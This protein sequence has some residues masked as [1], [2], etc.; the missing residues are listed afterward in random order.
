VN[1]CRRWFNARSS[2]A[3]AHTRVSES[4][5]LPMVRAQQFGLQLWK[6]KGGDVRRLGWRP[7]SHAVALSSNSHL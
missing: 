6:G 3:S 1:R 4:G 2:P 5:T 7:T